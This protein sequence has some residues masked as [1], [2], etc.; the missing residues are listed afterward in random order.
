M[1]TAIQLTGGLLIVDVIDGQAITFSQH[2]ACPDCNI[3]ID[4]IEP[5]YFLLIILWELALNAS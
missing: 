4:E 3:S 5:V 2:F 1:E